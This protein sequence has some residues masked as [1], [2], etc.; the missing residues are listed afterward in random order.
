MLVLWGGEDFLGDVSPPR[1]VRA[2][3]VSTDSVFK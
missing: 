1:V 2:A 3:E